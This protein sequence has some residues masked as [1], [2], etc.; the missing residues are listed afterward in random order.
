MQFAERA[1]MWQ[2]F[3]LVRAL[4]LKRPS[5]RHPSLKRPDWLPAITEAA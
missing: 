4:P 3:R 1:C 2:A 5:W